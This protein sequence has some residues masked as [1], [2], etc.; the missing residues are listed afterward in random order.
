MRECYRLKK[1][2]KFANRQSW[3]TAHNYVAKRYMSEIDRRAIF[4]DVKL[5]MDAKLW[6]E[7]FNRYNPPKK[8][9]YK[10]MSRP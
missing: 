2:S 1:L 6:T 7:E 10:N 4:E 5:Q 8:V 9:C 3:D